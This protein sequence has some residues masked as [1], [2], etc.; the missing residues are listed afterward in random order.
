MSFFQYES[1]VGGGAKDVIFWT[2][3]HLVA[4]KLKNLNRRIGTDDGHKVSVSVNCVTYFVLFSML[5]GSS[6]GVLI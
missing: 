6:L 2:D 4:T 5:S 1:V 3:D